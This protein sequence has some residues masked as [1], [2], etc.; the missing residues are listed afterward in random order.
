M[1]E[2]Q[3]VIGRALSRPADVPG[4][5]A[6]RARIVRLAAS[7]ERSREPVVGTGR[8]VVSMTTY[9]PRLAT[10]H[11]ALESIAAGD[12]RPARMVLAVDDPRTVESPPAPLARLIARGL[13]L[14][15]VHDDG[16][17]KKHV[18]LAAEHRPGDPPVVVADDDV[19]YGRRWLSSLLGARDRTPDLMLAH[20]ARVLRLDGEHVAPYRTWPL[21]HDPAASAR[22]VPTGVGGVLYPD[23]LLSALREEG[24]GFE[25]AA[26]RSDD[27]WVHVVALR[28]GI[29]ARQVAA[30]P[31]D[32]PSI[33][34][35]QA[36]RLHSTGAE[37]GGND[38]A[39]A[40][41]SPADVERLR[42]RD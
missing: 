24:R 31:L 12:V 14:R 42:S 22:I 20:R 18:S 2:R 8:A 19:L 25:G 5:L 7:A 28:H 29:G 11:L 3:G 41:Y 35:S 23:A 21:A 4:R 15:L 9:G 37:V 10:V 1:A 26:F 40:I 39:V 33:P 27:I 36:V 30:A 13:E 32:H 38:E 34:G 16:C 6:V 17:H